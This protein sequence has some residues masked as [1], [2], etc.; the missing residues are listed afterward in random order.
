[1]VLIWLLIIA[2]TASLAALV[3]PILMPGFLESFPEVCGRSGCLPPL[4]RGVI[5][6]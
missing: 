5:Q 1:M 2:A 4:D 6:P 3:L